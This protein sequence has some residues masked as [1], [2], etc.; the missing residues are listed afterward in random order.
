VNEHG[1]PAIVLIY[2][3]DCPNAREARSVLRAALE[4]LGLDPEWV[5]HGRG[6]PGVPE[7]F[8][9][10]GSPTV[11]VDGADV[12]GETAA[13]AAACCRVYADARGVRGV[14]AIET[15]I[16]AIKGRERRRRG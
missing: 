5:E 9:R 8:L 13:A 2:D 11:L 7:D 16:A 10:Y 15:I 6:T 3:A 4:R 14:P 1:L 12:A